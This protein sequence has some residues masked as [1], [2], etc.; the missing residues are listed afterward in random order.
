MKGQV[1]IEFMVYF[2]FVLIIGGIFLINHLTSSQR[3]SELKM[4]V[5]A[6]KL[7]KKISFE[8]N[9]AVIAG[10]G[11]ERR[12]YIQDKIAGFSTFTISVGNYSV[13]LDWDYRS[14][15]STIITESINGTVNKKWNLIRN[16]NGTVYV[17]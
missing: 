10:D 1:S 5:D 17:N 14:K 2:A 15:S 6:G 9:S 12:F 11:Y 8:I 7:L 4:D 16:V 3:L 13:F